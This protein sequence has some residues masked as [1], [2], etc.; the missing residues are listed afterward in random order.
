MFSSS[1]LGSGSD[2]P[3]E[4]WRLLCGDLGILAAYLTLPLHCCS[5]SEGVHKL[6][7]LETAHEM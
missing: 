1:R 6:Y 3:L 4:T 7:S 5:L 2:L